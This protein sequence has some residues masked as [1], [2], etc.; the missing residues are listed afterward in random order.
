MKSFEIWRKDFQHRPASFVA[1]FDFS[2]IDLI[3]GSISEPSEP[4]WN[5]LGSPASGGNAQRQLQKIISERVELVL[6]MTKVALS[7]RPGDGPAPAPAGAS[8]W[9][10]RIV[11]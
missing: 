2:L 10:D 11:T 9:P 6:D 8:D 3:T 5:P 1:L 4:R 7:T